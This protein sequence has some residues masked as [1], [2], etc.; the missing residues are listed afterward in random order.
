MYDLNLN[1]HFATR[2]DGEAFLIINQ[3][4]VSETYFC[5]L[6]FLRKSFGKQTKEIH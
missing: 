5:I 1:V 6:A 2:D 3:A 4:V